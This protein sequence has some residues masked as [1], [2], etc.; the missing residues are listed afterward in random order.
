MS[1]TGIIILFVY[2][3]GFAISFWILAAYIRNNADYITLSELVW[4]SFLSLFSWIVAFSLYMAIYSDKPIIK[5]KKK[6]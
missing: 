3:F 1:I 6:H 5:F 2:L 4:M